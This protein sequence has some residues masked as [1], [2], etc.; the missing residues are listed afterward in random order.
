MFL[1]GYGFYIAK[2]R[3]VQ[4]FVFAYQITFRNARSYSIVP[5]LKFILKHYLSDSFL[6]FIKM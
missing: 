4:L 3:T 6:G 2:V 1:K 5:E